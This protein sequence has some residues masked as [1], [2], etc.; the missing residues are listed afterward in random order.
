MKKI[1]FSALACL[2]LSVAFLP[3]ASANHRTGS[4]I[5]PELLVAGDFNQDGNMDLAV[6]C[7]GFDVVA[8]LLGD[9]QGGMTLAGHFP[10]DT[11]TKGLQA[12][13]VNRD[14]HLD[15]VN[16][17][18]WGYDETIL[19]GD[20]LGAF[21]VASPPSEVDGDGEPVRL[22]L[23]DFNNDGRLDIF[24]NAPDD[25]KVVLYFGDGKGNFPGP[26]LEI[27]GVQ[28]P[29]GMD[30]GD[31]NGDGKLDAA[32]CG[33]SHIAGACVVTVMLGD[34]AGGFT[35]STFSVDDLPASCK[36][37]DLNNDG[38]PDIVVAGALP[39]GMGSAGNFIST[40]L[41]NGRGGFALAQDIRLGLGNL[42]GDIALGD[43]D[44]DGKL[45]VAFPVTGA[46]LPPH[47]HSTALDIFFGDGH[48]HLSA[49]PVLTVGQEPHTVIAVDVN[50]DGHLDLAVT[51]RTDGTVTVLLGNGHGNFTVSSTT[52][53]LSPIP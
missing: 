36:I 38:I 43:F 40:Y 29:F 9:G 19:L 32:V 12:G 15:L 3:S 35:N 18:N 25:D 49:G 48:G 11:L 41:G 2:I 16:A 17:A 44:E 39:S 24:V 33:E 51:N 22:L 21:H 1:Q 47:V 28:Q 4:I 7:T 30:A 34:G 5:A 6:N 20:G 8:I 42:K 53:V 23:R 10:T 31:L 45:D 13:D 27:T 26:D 50:H 14:G 37:G 46:D 52:S